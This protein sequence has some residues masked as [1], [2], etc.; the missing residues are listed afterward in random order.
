MKLEVGQPPMPHN[1]NKNRSHVR[2]VNAVAT[3]L[4]GNTQLLDRNNPTE[5]MMHVAGNSSNNGVENVKIG[6]A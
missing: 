4:V 5:T 2:N 3:R 6:K 1:M